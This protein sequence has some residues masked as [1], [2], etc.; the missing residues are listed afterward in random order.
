ML[1][2]VL[3]GIF[4]VEISLRMIALGPLFFRSVTRVFD[5]VVVVLAVVVGEPVPQHGNTAANYDNVNCP[6]EIVYMTWSGV[7]EVQGG[8]SASPAMHPA[9]APLSSRNAGYICPFPHPSPLR[10]CGHVPAG[11]PASHGNRV[12][13]NS[14]SPHLAAGLVT[15]LWH[16]CMYPGHVSSQHCELLPLQALHMIVTAF[17]RALHGVFWVTARFHMRTATRPLLYASI[18]DTLSHI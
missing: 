11:A 7:E 5:I 9:L 3:L 8:C 1:L 16:T 15:L 12:H 10:I 4:V 14:G 18:A 6:A 2:L 13:S 17:F